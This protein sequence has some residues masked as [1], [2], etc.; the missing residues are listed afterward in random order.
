MSMIDVSI[1]ADVSEVTAEDVERAVQMTLSAEGVD[2]DLS[3]VL[4]DDETIHQMNRQFL[5]HDYATDVICFDLRDDG[6][7]VDAEIVVSVDTARREA[8]LRNMTF[9]SEVLLYCVHGTLHLL[10]YDDHDPEDKLR[11]HARQRALLAE[12]GYET[13]E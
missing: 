12:I 13:T 8:E 5:E 9:I 7:G 4:V 10:G 2:L 3:I 1:E 11:M 6:P